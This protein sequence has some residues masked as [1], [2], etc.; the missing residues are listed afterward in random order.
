MR[1]K[2]PDKCLSRLIG[3]SDKLEI[4]LENALSEQT[5]PKTYKDLTA[6][7]K[8]AVAIRRNLFGLPTQAEAESQRIADGKLKLETM[9]QS[10][11]DPEQCG[12]FVEIDPA[13]YSD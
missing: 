8:D 11:P 9:K 5:D 3:I 2:R 6:A 10:A 1:K 4:S 7:I 12:L 13:A